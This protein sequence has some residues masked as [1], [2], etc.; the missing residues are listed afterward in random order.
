MGI[1]VYRD[2]KSGYVMLHVRSKNRRV[3]VSTGLHAD[4]PLL[5]GQLRDSGAK[6]HRLREIVNQSEDWLLTHATA[7]P[8]QVKNALKEICTGRP[9]SKVLLT[10]ILKRMADSR[11]VRNT[12]ITYQH[13]AKIVEAFDR[14]ATIDDIDADWLKRLEQHEL[15]RGRSVNGVWLTLNKIK[16]AFN[17]AIDNELTT[18]YPFRGYR[19]RKEATRKRDLTDDQ[20]RVMTGMWTSS[21]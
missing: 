20:I 19:I 11:D 8:I 6:K 2:S 13:A 18:N 5:H 16:A 21:S 10:D 9:Q 1:S 12:V 15:D 17:Y 4:K 7:T 14:S 3:V